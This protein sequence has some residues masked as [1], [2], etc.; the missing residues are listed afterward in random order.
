MHI[1]VEE[2]RK[3]ANE[4]NFLYFIFNSKGKGESLDK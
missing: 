2:T 3:I 4:V 1:D